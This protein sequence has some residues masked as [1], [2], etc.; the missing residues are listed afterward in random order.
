MGR[1]SVNERLT[2]ATAGG[3]PFAVLA[4]HVAM[5]VIGLATGSV[6][7][8]ARK[9]GTWHRRSGVV[10]VWSMIAMA[11]SAVVIALY[12]GATTVIAGGLTA[13]LVLTAYLALKEPRSRLVD[14][15][16]MLLAFGFAAMEYYY[17]FIVWGMP[18]HKSE[19]V[20]AGIILFMGTVVLLAAIGDARMIRGGG[21]QGTRRIARHLWRMCFGLFIALG[22]FTAQLVKMPFI[23]P[24][25]R[26]L[27]VILAIST[28]PLILLLYW[29]WK[30][31]FRKNF[32]GLVTARP[33]EA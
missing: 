11:L 10:F 28:A 12:E 17:G 27:P 6:A 3:L 23:P 21:V 24:A 15:G 9:G 13:Y 4:F 5:G 22:S 2:L 29:M 25:M 30:V 26:S 31:R 16:L 14:I 1:L 7:I 18:G 20:P 19:G 8:A 33:V 32:R